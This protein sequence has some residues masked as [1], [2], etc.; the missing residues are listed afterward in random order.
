MDPIIPWR[1]E[2]M[3]QN[4]IKDELPSGL[5]EKWP[6]KT[7]YQLESSIS[8]ILMTETESV[9]FVDDDTDSFLA[10]NPKDLSEKLQR[11]VNNS[12]NWLKDNRL[13][14]AGDKSKILIVGTK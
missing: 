8:F 12:V 7:R 4:R 10:N 9:I 14:V 2:V 1:E 5:W 11:E 6:H 13:C 3:G